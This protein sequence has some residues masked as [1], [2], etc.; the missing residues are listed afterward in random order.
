MGTL[1]VVN[2]EA[3]G[4]ASFARTYADLGPV[5]RKHAHVWK[6]DTWDGIGPNGNYPAGPGTSEE[7]REWHRKEGMRC[8]AIV[9]DAI[10]I[11]VTTDS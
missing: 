7:T 6:A 4:R 10:A 11:E 8:L 5:E 1:E 2:A 9:N 3:L